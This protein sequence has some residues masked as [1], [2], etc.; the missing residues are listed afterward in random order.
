MPLH[1]WIQFHLS[2]E[3]V[4]GFLDTVRSNIQKNSNLFGR[5]M[6]LQVSAQADVISRQAR[7]LLPEFLSKMSVGTFQLHQQVIHYVLFCEGQGLLVI[8]YWLLVIGY[9]LERNEGLV[10]RFCIF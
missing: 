6:S 3:P 2:P 4:L 9:W 1:R 7:V 8:G 10:L 5:Q